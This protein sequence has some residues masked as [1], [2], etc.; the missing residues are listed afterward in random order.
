MENVTLKEN[1]AALDA[2]AAGSN[3][4]NEKLQHFYDIWK[5]NIQMYYY[6]ER[7]R[8][9]IVWNKWENQEARAKETTGKRFKK[10]REGK[11]AV[12]KRQQEETFQGKNEPMKT[13]GLNGAKVSI[14][15]DMAINKVL[16]IADGVYLKPTCLKITKQTLHISLVTN[17][18]DTSEVLNVSPREHV[19]LKAL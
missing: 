19:I 7:S 10:T 17:S 9:K 1:L 16:G 5:A 6:S 2:T 14:N 15:T 18:F 13:Y 8:G 12:L 11:Q 4:W 3:E